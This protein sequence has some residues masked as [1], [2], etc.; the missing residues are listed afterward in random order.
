MVWGCYQ[1]GAKVDK[2]QM[3]N[4]NIINLP[5]TEKRTLVV[6]RG[7]GCLIQSGRDRDVAGVD[8]GL[9]LG[10]KFPARNEWSHNIPIVI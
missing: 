9:H 7:R 3:L 6:V 4:K 2:A 10:S 1:E 8:T 5:M